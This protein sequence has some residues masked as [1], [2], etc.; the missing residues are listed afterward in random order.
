MI[1]SLSISWIIFWA[2]GIL[3]I[4][5]CLGRILLQLLGMPS[6]KEKEA[7]KNIGI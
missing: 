5:V 4:G 2:T 7:Q 1:I 3:L 6:K